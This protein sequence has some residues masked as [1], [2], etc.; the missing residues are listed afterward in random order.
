MK[1]PARD[2][3]LIEVLVRARRGGVRSRSAMPGRSPIS[4]CVRKCSVT[5]NVVEAIL[6]GQQ[7]RGSGLTGML[8]NGPQGG[9]SSD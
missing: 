4:R 6:D 1:K 5:P 3:T 2:E 8:G 7:Q 9:R